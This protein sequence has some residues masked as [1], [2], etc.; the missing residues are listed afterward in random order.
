MVRWPGP[1][2]TGFLS[3][4]PPGVVRIGPVRDEHTPALGRRKLV[5]FLFCF[6]FGF[7]LL[8]SRFRSDSRRLR[9]ASVH[10]LSTAAA[11]HHGRALAGPLRCKA[12]GLATRPAQQKVSAR[13]ISEAR[14]MPRPASGRAFRDCRPGYRPPRHRHPRGKHFPAARSSSRSC[15]SSRRPSAG[16]APHCS[17]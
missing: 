17:R 8:G 12:I 14:Y 4:Q 11:N 1:F 10:R 9:T 13:S 15:R 7:P 3:P 16:Y 2:G 5:L 6:F